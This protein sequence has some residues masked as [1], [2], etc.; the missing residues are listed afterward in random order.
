[1]IVEIKVIAAD[2]KSI[3]MTLDSDQIKQMNELHNVNILNETY[4]QIMSEINKK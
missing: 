1:M 2:G 4:N 3:S